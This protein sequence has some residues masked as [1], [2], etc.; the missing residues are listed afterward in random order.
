MM[1]YTF[2]RLLSGVSFAEADTRA[3]KALS[4]HR[5]GAMP[6]FG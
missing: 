3:R 5:F 4:D 1:T 6:D 2:N